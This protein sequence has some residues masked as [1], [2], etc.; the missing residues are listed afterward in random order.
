MVENILLLSS[1]FYVFGQTFNHPFYKGYKSKFSEYVENIY[2]QVMVETVIFAP[3][4]M[5]I[6]SLSICQSTSIG[7]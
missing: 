6:Q 5:K 4:N 7:L 3:N 1:Y 2:Y